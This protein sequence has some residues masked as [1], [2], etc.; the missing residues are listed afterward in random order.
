M[1]DDVKLAFF[2]VIYFI[3]TTQKAERQCPIS[4]RWYRIFLFYKNILSYDAVNDTVYIKI[5]YLIL[6]VK[7]IK[8]LYN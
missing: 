7:K 6:L 1:I 3:V 4:G 5:E 2:I 8:L